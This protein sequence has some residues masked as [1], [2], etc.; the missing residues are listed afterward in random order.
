[1]IPNSAAPPL[2]IGNHRELL[3]AFSDLGT[4]V[5][6]RIGPEHRSK[7]QKEWYC[8]RRLLLTLGAENLLSYPLQI[9]K[10]SLR[11]SSSMTDRAAGTVSKSRKQ[12]TR[13]GSES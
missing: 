7:D 3:T 4:V 13:T 12:P 10:Q 5:G 9:A 6:P 11:I 2:I 8:L 1:M